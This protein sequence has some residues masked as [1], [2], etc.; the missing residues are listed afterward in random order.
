MSEPTL[1]RDAYKEAVL[2]TD[3]LKMVSRIRSAQA[4]IERRLKDSI[5]LG[6][7]EHEELLDAQEGIQILINERT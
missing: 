3:N 2:E 4:A 5:E 1:W 7:V 6:S